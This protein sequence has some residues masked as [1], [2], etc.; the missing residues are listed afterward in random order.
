MVE[1]RKYN[2]H[3]RYLLDILLRETITKYKNL[4]QR[5]NI[6]YDRMLKEF[7]RTCELKTHA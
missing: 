5:N 1:S 4:L 3:D 2:I 6:F 7:E